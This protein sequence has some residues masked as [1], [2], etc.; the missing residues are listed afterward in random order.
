MYNRAILTTNSPNRLNCTIVLNSVPTILSFALTFIKNIY[1]A[2]ILVC[3]IM[4]SLV[5]CILR[6]LISKTQQFA[7]IFS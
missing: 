1:V 7:A 4:E 5:G 6:E 3:Q 2:F